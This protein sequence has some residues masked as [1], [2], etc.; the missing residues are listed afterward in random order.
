MIPDGDMAANLTEFSANDN[1][2]IS[3]GNSA[4]DGSSNTLNFLSFSDA[5]FTKIPDAMLHLNVLKQLTLSNIH[6]LDWNMNVMNH[7]C[8][9][10]ESFFF[11]MSD[12]KIWP[13]WLKYCSHLTELS[14]I[15]GSISSIPDGALDAMTNSLVTLTLDNNSLIAI[16][17][18]LSKLTA[19]EKLSVGFNNIANI[20][21]LP[22][23][24]KLSSLSLTNNKIFEANKLSEALRYYAE[25][26]T[27]VDIDHNKLTFIPDVSFLIKVGGFDFSYNRISDPYSG[28]L[29]NDTYEIDLRYNLLP[30]V[31]RFMSNLTMKSVT[32]LLLSSNVITE[33]RGTD[34]PL[35]AWSLQLDY[36]LIREITDSSF[37]TNSSLSNINLNYN[38]IFRISQFAFRNVPLLSELLMKGTQL[39]RV[40]LALVSIGS[41]NM[42]DISDC[43][44]LVCTCEERSL[45]PWFQKLSPDYVSGSCGLTSVYTFFVSLSPDCPS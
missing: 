22:Q 18:A 21:W 27:D 7:L 2:L 26:I 4:F 11:S 17:N 5:H 12:I 28:G 10:L 9:T 30:S 41:L 38:L 16:P 40:P 39:T 23:A 32:N 6:I 24:S 25:T 29:P 8:E 33:I 34:I 42:L 44:K 31:P 19:L 1:P 36:N 15:D 45:G 35:W 13:D 20:D 14:L 37:P 3:V 43:S